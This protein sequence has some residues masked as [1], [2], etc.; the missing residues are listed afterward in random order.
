[1]KSKIKKKIKRKKKKM[2]K[3]NKVKERK[4]KIKRKIKKKNNTDNKINPNHK[5]KSNKSQ[6]EGQLEEE[7]N[8][9]EFKDYIISLGQGQE[10]ETKKAILE[11]DIK[12]G[13]WVLLQ[14]VIYSLLLCLI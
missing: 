7:K 5:N 3:I 14:N 1:M 8:V 11:Y 10:E 6:D 4:K 12:N 13:E 2:K 9:Y